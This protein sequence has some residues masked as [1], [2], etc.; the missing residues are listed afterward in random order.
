MDYSKLL[1]QDLIELLEQRSFADFIYKEE[2]EM[3]KKLLQQIISKD[4]ELKELA[5]EVRTQQKMREYYQEQIES[6]SNDLEN[7]QREKRQAYNFSSNLDKKNREKLERI[8]IK[9]GKF[10]KFCK[11]EDSIEFF[12][13]IFK[14]VGLQSIDEYVK[15]K[16]DEFDNL[17]LDFDE[18]DREVSASQDLDLDDDDLDLDFDEF[19]DDLDDSLSAE[20]DDDLDDDLDEDL[21]LDDDLDDLDVDFDEL[22]DDPD[23]KNTLKRSLKKNQNPK[24]DY[25]ECFLLKENK[26][27]RVF[28]SLFLLDLCTFPI[29]AKVHKLNSF[30]KIT[31]SLLIHT[32]KIITVFNRV[33]CRFITN[34]RCNIFTLHKFR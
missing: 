23:I 28:N 7:L 4:S 2:S 31:H 34:W 24:M 13:Q 26:R 25:Q 19:E 17:D 14:W 16:V 5:D 3:R 27:K 12:V 9:V 15:S 22:E 30:A 29:F 20:L 1:K 11:D 18:L 32:L 21:E 10:L 8:D 6:L 33:F